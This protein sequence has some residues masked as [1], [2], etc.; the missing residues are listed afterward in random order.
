[1]TEEEIQQIVDVVLSLLKKDSL[2]INE[3]FHTNVLVESDCVELN[4]GRKT[5]LADIREFIQEKVKQ[6]IEI[7]TKNDDKTVPSDINVFSSIRT[8]FEILKNNDLLK[9]IFLRKD[10][11]DTAR[12]IITFL[13]GLLLG[14][15]GH[16]IIVS[17]SGIVTAILDELKNVF[18]IVSPDFVSG[19]LGNGYVLKYDQKTGRSYLEVDELLVRKLAYFVELIIKRL[20]HVGGEIILTPASLKCSKVEVYDTYYRCYFEQDDGDKSIVQEFKA[21]DQARCQ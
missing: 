20:S 11:A 21:G 10:Q 16:G 6:S 19:D 2:T 12:E 17:N 18:S 5:S 1:M 7:I 14:D 4:D 15:K 13:K 8:L 3:L 9:K